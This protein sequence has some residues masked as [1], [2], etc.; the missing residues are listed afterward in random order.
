MCMQISMRIHMR[1]VKCHG[2]A[3]TTYQVLKLDFYIEKKMNLSLYL[4]PCKN[5]GGNE[6]RD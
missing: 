2:E 1:V 3:K 5:L 4:K 6:W